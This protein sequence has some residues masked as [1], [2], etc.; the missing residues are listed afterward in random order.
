MV[1]SRRRGYSRDARGVARQLIDQTAS[2]CSVA[3]LIA[4]SPPGASR[5]GLSRR[6]SKYDT[7]ATGRGVRRQ[8]FQAQ[9]EVLIRKE[10]WRARREGNPGYQT[11]K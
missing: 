6:T 8:A 4:K 1:F 5:L 3:A 11:R 2:A 7:C 9:R 10:N